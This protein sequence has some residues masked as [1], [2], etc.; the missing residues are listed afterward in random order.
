MQPVTADYQIKHI[1]VCILQM[2]MAVGMAAMNA[3]SAQQNLAPSIPASM[4][5]SLA[6]V[7]GS[8]AKNFPPL[9]PTTAGFGH[10][11]ASGNLASQL[12]SM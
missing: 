8:P 10:G 7:P 6:G 4:A 1:V 12:Q 9:N 2:D 5:S 11:L 3:N